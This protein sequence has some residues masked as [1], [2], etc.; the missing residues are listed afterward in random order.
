MKITFYGAT[1]TVTGSC[2]EITT[3]K[4]YRI[5]VDCGL[6]Q[7]P[8]EIKERNYGDFPF[9]PTEIDAVLLTHAHID[10][11]GLIPKLCKQGF[12][13][14]IYTTEV[15]VDLCS[16]MLPDSGYIQEMEV[17]R[18][19]RKLARAN[20]NLLEPIYTVIDAEKCMK[21]FVGVAY[22][23][24]IEILPEIQVTFQDAGHIL[25]S[26]MI[27]VFAD[28]LKVLFSGDIGNINQPIINDPTIITEADYIVM[29]STYGNRFH[30]ETEDKMSQLIRIIKKTFRKGG[31]LVIPAFA[32]ERTQGLIYN[33]KKLDIAGEIPD[34]DVYL[35]SPLAIKATEIFCKYPELYDE[36]AGGLNEKFDECILNFPGLKYSL[37]ADE[38]KAINFLKNSKIIIS[39]S[40]MCDAGRIKHH[41]KHNLWRSDST[42]LFVGYQAQGTLGRR[43]LD[44]EKTVR[45]HG[46]EIAVNAD[47]ERIEG[48]SAHADQKTLVEW[49]KHFSKKPQKIFLVHGEQNAMLTLAKVIEEETQNSV[50]IPKFNQ[51]IEL[52]K[53][54]EITESIGLQEKEIAQSF[55]YFEETLQSFLNNSEN[56]SM[57]LLELEKLKEKI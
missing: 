39:A 38:S 44:G 24:K 56:R 33:L 12:K 14:K 54:G 36:E 57:I 10:H 28:D 1:E 29:E 49:V 43:I 17:E 20:K 47:I 4:G 42:I 53:S 25:G 27:E 11:S 22:N 50:I 3:N 32:V 55:K 9:D 52:T 37:T 18:K 6:Y 2:F 51:T 30:L 7:G 26:A 35:D 34:M 46:E 40:G 48:F 23:K 8:K 41:L 13:G 15:T 16:I 21:Q 5:L 19:N 45:I 31:N